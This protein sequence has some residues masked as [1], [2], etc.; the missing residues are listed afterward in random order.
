MVGRL[1]APF[2]GPGKRPLLIAANAGGGD[3]GVKVFVQTVMAGYLMPFAA[4]LVEP[5]ARA[6]AV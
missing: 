2:K 6:P 1:V 5:Q 3:P 4:F